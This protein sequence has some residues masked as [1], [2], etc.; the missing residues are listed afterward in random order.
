MGRTEPSNQRLGIAPT[1]VAQARSRS[2]LARLEA[3]ASK[4]SSANVTL[5]VYL[6]LEK[7]GRVVECRLLHL[8]VGHT[9]T[10]RGMI[11]RRAGETG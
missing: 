11:S 8:R 3:M 2:G 4:L 1:G 5:L 7:D 6:V 9:G 10:N